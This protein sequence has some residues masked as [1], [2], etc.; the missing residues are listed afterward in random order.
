MKK[1]KDV[2]NWINNRFKKYLST[3]ILFLTYLLTSVLMGLLLRYNTIGKIWNFKALLCDV[4]VVGIIGS[5]GYLVKPKKQFV[6]FVTVSVIY[7]ILCI[8]NSFYYMFYNN[9]VSVSMINTFSMLGKV[10]DS[11]TTKLRPIYFVYMLF[12]LV[13]VLVNKRLKKKNYYYNVGKEEKGKAMF[14]KTGFASLF[15]LLLVFVFVSGTEMNKLR[16]NWNRS[17]VV[18]SFGIYLYTANDVVQSIAPSVKPDLGYE[19]AHEAF[20]EFYSKDRNREVNDYTGIFEGK[21]VLFIHG[22]SVQNFLVDLKINGEEITPN[23]NKMVREG[24]YFS[25]FYPQISIGTSSDTEYTLSTGFL[26]SNNGT[27]FVNYYNRKYESIQNAFKKRG[28]YTFS[29][30]A[31]EGSY[32]NRDEM[33]KTLGY[34]MF[35]DN[36]YYEIPEDKLSED[37]VGLGLS[38]SAFYKQFIPILKSIREDNSK[39]M[40]TVISLS[41]HS[42]FNDLEKYGE[43]DLSIKLKNGT[44]MPY[45]EGSEM[46]NYLKS[47]HYADKALGEFMNMLLKEN[48]LKD[49][50]V[51]FYGD[52]EAR[53]S[54]NSFDLLYNYDEE[55]GKIKNELDPT[56]VSLGNY[57][58]EML[59]NTP[60]II[61]TG[62]YS[63]SREIN[64]VMGMW[65]VYP[66]VANM[67]NLEYTYPLGNDI[68]SKSEKIVVFPS[69]DIITNK[70]YY[71]NFNE[72]YVLLKDEAIDVEYIDR[73]KEYAD[74][75]LELSKNLLVY[76]LLNERDR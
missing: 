62:D 40:G 5:F 8:I 30:H 10:S 25:K 20:K 55:T 12:P 38:D 57:R 59:R 13:M 31:N 35:Y 1:I 36:E 76:D 26:P 65:D 22:E 72:E 28:Y 6:Y 29:T 52:H 17:Y 73:I 46:G 69:G 9:F 48:I 64:D 24:I 14:M 4:V 45:L 50:V 54:R 60:L 37:F 51:I 16:K 32:W 67:F 61:W 47:A 42:P 74:I 23:L 44:I 19:E 34:D 15:A 39:Y 56:Y 63:L 21:N 2:Y 71:S 27:V 66:T 41:N 58:Y 33:Y 75:R 49:T 70:V 11:V 7:T 53:L 18:G 3:N 43:L 68:F